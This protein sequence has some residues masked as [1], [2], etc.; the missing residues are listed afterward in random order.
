MKYICLLVITS[1]L[2]FDCAQERDSQSDDTAIG[3]RLTPVPFN[4]VKLEDK[5]WKPRLKTQVETLVPFA[6]DKTQGAQRALEQAGN[7]LAGIE[8]ELPKPHRFQSSD[9][10]KVMEGAAYL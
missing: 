7:F 4:E 1:I 6:L 8:D 9:L 2:L 3:F 5:F 10:Y